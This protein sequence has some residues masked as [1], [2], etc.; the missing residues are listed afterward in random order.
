M[1][2]KIDLIRFRGIFSTSQFLKSF[3]TNLQIVELELASSKMNERAY[4]FNRYG[5][6]KIADSTNHKD[7]R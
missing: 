4:L 6:N 7:G 5:E 1:P 3:V 2:E